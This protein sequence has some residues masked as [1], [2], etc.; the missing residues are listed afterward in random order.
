MAEDVEGH[1][2]TEPAPNDGEAECEERKIKTNWRKLLVEVRTFQ[3]NFSRKD[4]LKALIFGLLAS[5]W[6]TF[7]DF[8][9]AADDH[10]TTIQLINPNNTIH[11]ALNL[12]GDMIG[13]VTY[14]IISLPSILTVT[15]W[16]LNVDFLCGL[17]IGKKNGMITTW[18][19]II[20]TIIKLALCFYGF[21]KLVQWTGFPGPQSTDIFKVIAVM[22]AALV[23]GVKILALFVHGREMKKLSLKATLAESSYESA[24]Q[25]IFVALISLWAKHITLTGGMLMAS[26]LVMIGK[27]A[28]EGYLTFGAKNLL[29][30]VSL[31]QHVALLAKY[32]PVFLFTAL[33]RIGSFTALMARQWTTALQAQGF[34]GLS[35]LLAPLVIIKI[36]G[37]IC[38]KP[39]NGA[40]RYMEDLTLG[41]F[42]TSFVSEMSTISN[43]GARGREKSRRLQLT[44]SAAF[45]IFYILML[46]PIIILKEPPATGGI[47]DFDIIYQPNP[48]TLQAVGITSIFFGVVAF[49]LQIKMLRSHS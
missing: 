41:D 42:I 38:K 36:C 1:W 20:G 34:V 8:N 28:A 21:P 10:S 31:W 12:D 9:F 45:L 49:V 2:D 15:T 48:K 33:F 22:S 3:A 26:S 32:V 11:H 6:D 24:I 14:F 39:G 40:K 19:V 16:I 17:K 46:S 27:A 30:G 18:R 37:H 7:S 35:C 25:L 44:A 5:G 13:R 43:W 29:D 23:I 47:S 4:F